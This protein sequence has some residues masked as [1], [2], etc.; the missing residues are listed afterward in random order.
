MPYYTKKPVTI[1]AVQLTGGVGNVR[2]CMEFMGCTVTLD[3][4]KAYDAFEDYIRS[5]ESKGLT[6]HTLE[7]D[8]VA[9]LGDFIIKGV[10]G[11]FYPCKPDIFHMTY[12]PVKDSPYGFCPVCGLP[13]VKRERRPGGNDVCAGNHCYPSRDALKE[14]RPTPS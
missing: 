12:D 10:Q 9:S 14:P 4:E 11:E 13:G 5:V 6:I 1:E 2:A 3:C 7:G 8:M